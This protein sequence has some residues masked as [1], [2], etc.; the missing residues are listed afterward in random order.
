MAKLHFYYSA[1]NAG[2]STTLLQSSYNYNERGMDTLLFT[3]IVDDRFGAGKIASRIGL[4]KSAI[5]IGKN[6]DIF[7]ATKKEHVKNPNIKCVLVDEAQFLTKKQVEQLTFICDFL[8]IPVLT[9][10]IRSDFRGEPFEGST[11]LLAWADNIIE[12][13]TI[14]HCGKKATMNLR[15]D[16]HGNVAVDGAQIDIGGN[17]KYIATCRKHFRLKKTK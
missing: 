15:M 8:N 13:K 17:E 3:P 14:C 2:K 1:M 6:A 10:G 12:L 9:Y 7:I 4:E 11:Y 5:P 16:E